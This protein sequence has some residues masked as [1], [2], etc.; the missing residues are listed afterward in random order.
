MVVT[1]D[2]YQGED[3]AELVD[4]DYDPL[5]P[6]IEFAGAAGGGEQDLLFPEAGTNVAASFGDA[7]GLKADL[8]AGCDVVV[9]RTIVNQRVAPAPM[10]T[11]AAAA[12]WGED[13]RLTAWIPNQGAQDT[14]EVLAGSVVEAE[15]PSVIDQKAPLRVDRRVFTFELVQPPLTRIEGRFRLLQRVVRLCPIIGCAHERK[16]DRGNRRL[17]VPVCRTS[18]LGLFEIAIGGIGQLNNRVALERLE[19]VINGVNQ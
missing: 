10:E 3:A 12:A 8:F 1:E 18:L 7:A 15:E 19:V 11:R 14:R 13:G 6:V 9:T 16:S 4:A 17:L 2:R 5:P